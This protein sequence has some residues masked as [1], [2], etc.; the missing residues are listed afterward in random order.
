MD[1]GML[2]A[3][4]HKD[5]VSPLCNNK[6]QYKVDLCAA[7][8][9]GRVCMHYVDVILNCFHTNLTFNSHIQNVSKRF[10][11]TY[12]T[13]SEDSQDEKSSSEYRSANDF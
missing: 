8:Y 5:I 10:G 9:K 2:E 12:T 1:N 4:F 11:Q 3:Q 7:K 6:I 13:C